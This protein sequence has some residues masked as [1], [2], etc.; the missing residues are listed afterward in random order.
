V[1]PSSFSG[2]AKAAATPGHRKAWSKAQVLSARLLAWTTIICSE[3]IPNL[4]AAGG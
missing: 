1:R 4:T 2:H 3:A